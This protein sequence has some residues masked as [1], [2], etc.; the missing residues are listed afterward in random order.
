MNYNPYTSARDRRHIRDIYRQCIRA[1]GP[2]LSGYRG[3]SIL[4]M[5]G[6]LDNPSMIIYWSA[7]PDAVLDYVIPMK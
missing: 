4:D 5:L 3:W 2:D 7:I 6:D 1:T